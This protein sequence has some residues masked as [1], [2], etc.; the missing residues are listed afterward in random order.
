MACSN[1]HCAISVA[2]GRQLCPHQASTCQ[3]VVSCD[4]DVRLAGHSANKWV[5]ILQAPTL[6][7]RPAPRTSWPRASEAARWQTAAL[8]LAPP[9]QQATG[10]SAPARQR[11]RQGCSRIPQPF[12]TAISQVQG[13]A[14]WAEVRNRKNRSLGG[15]VVST[16]LSSSWMIEQPAEL[17]T[18]ILLLLHMPLASEGQRSGVQDKPH[19][20]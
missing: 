8:S 16:A 14:A 12:P 11:P 9:A 19:K 13:A 1:R 6:C 20:I 10:F 3:A 2:C 15:C 17:C 5:C 4:L 18:N 7:R